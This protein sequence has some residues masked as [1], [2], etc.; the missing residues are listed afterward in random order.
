M[1]GIAAGEDVDIRGR[2]VS[3]GCWGRTPAPAAA[4]A[5]AVAAVGAGGEGV[6]RRV[7]QDCEQ[8][9]DWRIRSIVPSCF[10]FPS[11]KAAGPRPQRCRRRRLWRRR[12]R[13]PA[14]AALAE[15]ERWWPW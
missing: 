14:A 15:E 13:F 5:V 9:E 3:W 4:V 11:R 10:Q 1:V 6:R 2:A 8:K 12:S 7:S